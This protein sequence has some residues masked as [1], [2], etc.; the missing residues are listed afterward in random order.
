M[1]ENKENKL[2]QDTIQ[3]NGKIIKFPKNTKASNALKFLEQ[4]KV[5]PKH[6]WYIII[7][8]QEQ[9]LKMVKYNR[10]QGVNLLD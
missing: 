9:D 6:T 5:N 7:E 10:S 2:E 3:L 4:V 1:E 8:D